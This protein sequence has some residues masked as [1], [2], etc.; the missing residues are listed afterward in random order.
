[1][2]CSRSATREFQKKC[3][4]KMQEVAQGEGRTVL[5]VSHN[6]GAVRRLCDRAVYLRNGSVVEVGAA[7]PVVETYLNS[8]VNADEKDLL[9]RPRFPGL[10]PTLAGFT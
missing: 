1:M 10:V 4:G 9:R 8:T 2:K 3:L 6:M 5:F 7:D